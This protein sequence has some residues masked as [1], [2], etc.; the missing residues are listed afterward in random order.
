MCP[1][2]KLFRS[3]EQHALFNLHYWRRQYAVHGDSFSKQCWLEAEAL[4]LLLLRIIS[5]LEKPSIEQ[6]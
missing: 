6:K 5:G 3:R 2:L 4:D 1:E